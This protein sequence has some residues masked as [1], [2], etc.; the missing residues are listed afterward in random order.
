[1]R[2]MYGEYQKYVLFFF[3]STV[4]KTGLFQQSSLLDSLM[5]K[6]RAIQFFLEHDSSKYQSMD[7]FHFVLT[8]L[9]RR[10]KDLGILTNG[11]VKII[12]CTF[13]DTPDTLV[14]IRS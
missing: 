3:A 9:G 2:W 6:R 8:F 7:A 5:R 4:K 1:M 12:S 14:R 13:Y 11:S 10:A